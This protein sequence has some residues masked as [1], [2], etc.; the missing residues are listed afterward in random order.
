MSRNSSLST[1]PDYE[2]YSL[3]ANSEE[4][5]APFRFAAHYLDWAAK[6]Y[7]ARFTPW[8]IVARIVTGRTSTPR[9]TSADVAIVKKTAS[10]VRRHL[11]QHYSRELENVNGVG[12]RAT[13]GS[14]DVIKSRMPQRQRQFESAAAGMQATA[15]LVNLSDIPNNAETRPL[16]EWFAA[17]VQ[18]NLRKLEAVQKALAL[19]AALKTEEK[20]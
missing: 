10:R 3:P 12:V 14:L 4:R 1:I 9:E 11:I 6:N 16:K 7:P 8:N 20:K 13:T 5:N 15:A 17:S 19:P 2:K 18:P